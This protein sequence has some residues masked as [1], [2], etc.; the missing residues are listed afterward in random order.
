MRQAVVAAQLVHC[1]LTLTHAVAMWSPTTLLVYVWR[2]LLGNV[3]VLATLDG[4]AGSLHHPNCINYCTGNGAP[5][6]AFNV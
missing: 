3:P 2:A 5:L 1:R 6:P 4:Q